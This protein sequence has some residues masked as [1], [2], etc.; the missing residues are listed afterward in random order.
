ML[1]PALCHSSLLSIS[2]LCL[3]DVVNL[4]CAKPKFDDCL[5]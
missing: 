4:S 2:H 1:V 3:R 5:K